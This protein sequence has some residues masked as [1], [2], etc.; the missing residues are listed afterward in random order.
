MLAHS[1]VTGDWLHLL[2]M[3]GF[4]GF[5]LGTH[6]GQHHLNGILVPWVPGISGSNARVPLKAEEVGRRG[7][8]RID[9]GRSW[10]GFHPVAGSHREQGGTVLPREEQ[11]C[12]TVPNK[13]VLIFSRN[14][15]GKEP[16]IPS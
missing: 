13:F 5:E 6:P 14:I 16:R 8:N 4:D 15:L 11:V 10:S 9:L 1:V 3:T 12:A 2:E 7:R